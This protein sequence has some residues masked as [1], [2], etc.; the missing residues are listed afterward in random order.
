MT[1]WAVWAEETGSAIAQAGRWRTVRSFDAHGPEG[2]LVDVDHPEGRRL[3]SFASNDYL[4][5]TQHP[6]VRAA[7]IEA[8]DRWGTGAG[9]ARLVVGSRP[10]HHDLEHALADWCHTETALLFPTGFAANLSVMSVFGGPGVRILSDEFNHASIID[11]CRMARAETAV[12]RHADA[13]HLAE[14]LV[15]ARADG[16]SRTIVVTDT[17]FSMDGDVAPI[18]AIAE[19]ATKHGSL[20]VVDEAHAVLGPSPDLEGLDALRVGTLSKTLGS[21]GGFVAGPRRLLDLLVNIAR[22]FIFTT[23]STPADSAAALAAIGVVRSA[24]GD[25]LRDRLRGH[26][27]RIAPG[28]PSP[29][30]PILVGDER[31]AVALADRLAD[32]GLLVPAIR[33]PTVPVGTSR[34]R[35]ALSAA[36]TE[37]QID[38]LAHALGMLTTP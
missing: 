37:T 16:V 28:H 2:M 21:L 26:V 14:L 25:R 20:L 33:P 18:E 5:L 24:E 6:A 23:G 38:A 31:E 22:P 35:L 13:D 11:G 27:E 36:H 3:V 15:H 8:I 32:Q 10:V 4:G 17:V 7:A 30:I 9:A 1:A 34:L 19:L 29:V 12:Y